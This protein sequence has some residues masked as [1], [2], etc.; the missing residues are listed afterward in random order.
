IDPSKNPTYVINRLLDKGDLEAARWVLRH[1]S[2]ELIA[3]TLRTKRD[4]AF[5]VVNKF[6]LKHG[7]LRQEV[8]YRKF[9]NL[10][11]SLLGQS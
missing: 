10:S 9:P 7:D 2:R 11:G 4:F 6:I 3:E 1:F 8:A 5:W